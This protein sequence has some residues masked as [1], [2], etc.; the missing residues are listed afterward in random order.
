[1]PAATAAAASLYQVPQGEIWL[2]N[3]NEKFRFELETPALTAAVRGT[4][5][6]LRVALDGFTV[7]ALLTGSLVLRN[8]QGEV[9]LSP[10]EEGLARP[11]AAPTKRVLVEPADAV[12]WSLAYPGLVSFRDLPLTPASDAVRGAG[13]ASPRGLPGAPGRDQLRPGTPGT[14]QGGG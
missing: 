11:G 14:G 12:Q 6:N 10:G 8:P 5:F 9:S 13:G 2:R 1:V 4:E 3:S 7:L